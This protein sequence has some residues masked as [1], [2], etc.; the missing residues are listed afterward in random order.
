MKS[1]VNKTV[2]LC[3]V[4]LLTLFIATTANAQE[5]AEV[6]ATLTMTLQSIKFKA[7]AAVFCEP[8]EAKGAL[9]LFAL[10]LIFFGDNG[11][12]FFE[13]KAY[14]EAGIKKP[15]KLAAKRN[16][17]LVDLFAKVKPDLSATGTDTAGCTENE[18]YSCLPQL[19]AEPDGCVVPDIVVRFVK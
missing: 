13:T 9:S 3:L 12:V 10:G 18:D 4:T 17:A 15:L 19:P 11:K 14:R 7:G 5:Q 16:R 8:E 6:D 1:K 2:V